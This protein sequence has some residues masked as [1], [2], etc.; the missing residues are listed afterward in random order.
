MTNRSRANVGMV[1][2]INRYDANGNLV[3]SYTNFPGNE[4][5]TDFKVGTD[6]SVYLAMSFVTSNGSGGFNDAGPGLAAQDLTPA[7][8]R[9]ARGGPGEP[10]CVSAGLGKRAPASALAPTKH[11]PLCRQCRSTGS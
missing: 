5:L 4:F 8:V 9:P 6:G 7:M 11:P 3:W 2:S 10:M 1:G